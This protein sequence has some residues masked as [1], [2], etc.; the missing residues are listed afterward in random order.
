MN[1]DLR[2]FVREALA[3]GVP[4]DDI[5][6]ALLAARWRP[7]EVDAALAEWIDGGLAVPVPRRKAHLS[8]REAFL[9]LLLFATLYTAAFNTGAILFHLIERVLPDRAMTPVVIDPR[10]EGLRW[11]VASLLIALPVF[12]YTGRLITAAMIDEPEQRTSGVRRWLTYLTLFVATMVLIGD[13]VAVVRGLLSGELV[14]R[15]LL[16]ALVVGGIAGVIFYH[17]LGDL[18][19]EETE[20][21][22]PG[23][24]GWLARA[25]VAAMALTAIAGLLVAGTP[26]RARVRQGDMLRIEALQRLSFRLDAYRTRE[27]HWPGSLPELSASDAGAGERLEIVDPLTRA[28]FEYAIVD[29]THVRVCARFAGAD[30][31]GPGN[32]VSEYWTH[33]AGSHCYVFTASRPVPPVR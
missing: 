20:T 31:L 1:A 33:P 16:K 4:R 7:D 14:P 5:R 3:R 23:R 17:H 9:H 32:L 29:S 25:G 21:P 24:G 8:A 27:G 15:F 22:G 18:R 13:F 26:N 30:S 12:L 11:A 19:R 28:P 2:G 6:R 10:L